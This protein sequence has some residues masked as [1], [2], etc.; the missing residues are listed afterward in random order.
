MRD[1]IDLKL[2]EITEQ[3]FRLKFEEERNEIKIRAKEQII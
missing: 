3:E 1:E 2:C